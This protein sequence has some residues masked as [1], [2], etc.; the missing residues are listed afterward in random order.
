MQHYKPLDALAIA[1]LPDVHIASWRLS[2]EVGELSLNE[3]SK[4]MDFGSL[5]CAW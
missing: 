1:V 5:N 4:G 3:L 2:G